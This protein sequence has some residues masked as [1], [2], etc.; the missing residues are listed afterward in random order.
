MASVHS[1][2]TAVHHA[3]SQQ[4]NHQLTQACQ[5]EASIT[6]V[7]TAGRMRQFSMSQTLAVDV[8]ACV[9]HCD[10]LQLLQGAG[11]GNMHFCAA[12][13]PQQQ[14]TEW[15]AAGLVERN[16]HLMAPVSQ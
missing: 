10:H 8:A 3:V 14:P 7:C 4:A 16:D 5:Q 12:Q 15:H 13:G 1:C 6:R 2:C 11:H 9:P